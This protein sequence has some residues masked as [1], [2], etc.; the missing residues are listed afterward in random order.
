MTVLLCSQFPFLWA[1]FG[2]ASAI[3][4]GQKMDWNLGLRELC[5]NNFQHN[6][7]VK[8]YDSG[9]LKWFTGI[10]GINYKFRDYYA[11]KSSRQL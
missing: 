2:S 10:I 3:G 8:E 4:G 9:I 6:D 1:L 7:R 11:N 5:P